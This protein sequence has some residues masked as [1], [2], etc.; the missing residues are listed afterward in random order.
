[1][2]LFLTLFW[3]GDSCHWSMNKEYHFQML[4]LIDKHFYLASG[5]ADTPYKMPSSI[6]G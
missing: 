4:A 2:F 3:L 6:D 1:M 5:F